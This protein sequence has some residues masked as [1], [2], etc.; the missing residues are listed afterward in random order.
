MAQKSN[1]YENIKYSW[2]SIYNLYIYLFYNV[3]KISYRL[4]HK[5]FCYIFVPLNF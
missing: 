3:S 4:V 2:I 5:V 1:F